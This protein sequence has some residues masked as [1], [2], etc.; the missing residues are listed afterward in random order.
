MKLT[1]RLSVLYVEDDEDSGFM[2]STLLGF[3]D[4][5]VL[6]SASIKEALHLA[7]NRYFELYLLDNRLPD[8]TG[9]E[10]C[11]QLH[12]LNPQIPIVFFS[13]KAYESDK[14][15]GLAAGASA[16]LIKPNVETVALTIFNLVPRIPGNKN[17]EGLL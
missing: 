11:Q 8:G 12:E 10:L 3:S 13:G 6:V 16:Y 14:Q 7:Q 9:L 2:L 4:I 1:K 5:D 17:E 15:K